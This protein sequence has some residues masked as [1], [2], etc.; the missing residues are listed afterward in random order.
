MNPDSGESGFLLPAFA[1]ALLLSLL[2]CPFVSCV[3]KRPEPEG[4]GMP[5]AGESASSGQ[6]SSTEGGESR[7]A[8]QEPAEQGGVP[9][10]ES[11]PAAD[12]AG[13]VPPGDAPPDESA[14]A[15]DPAGAP[16]P[17]EIADDAVSA[18]PR[19]MHGSLSVRYRGRIDGDDQDHEVGGLLALDLADPGVPWISGH[20][21][22]RV[23]V[24]LEG[25]DDDEV[26]SDLSDTYDS[27]VIPKLYLAYADIA[28]DARPEDSPGT[29]RVGRQSDPRLPEVLRLD[30]LSYLTRPMGEN[31]VEVGAYGGIPVHLYESSAEG[32]LTYGTFVE[33]RPWTDG[34]ARLDWMHLEDELTLGDQRDDLLS[35]GLWQDLARRWRLEAEY[36]HLE[37]DPRDLRLRA[38]FTDPDSETIVRAGY[39]ELLETQRAHATE[40]DPFF[41]QLL[42]HFP[43]RQTTLNVSQAFGVHTV[44]DAGFD[45][46]RVRDSGDVG[47]FN[48]DWERYYATAT[49]H[50]LPAEGVAL[51]VTADR[52]D[53]DDRDTST[54]GADLSYAA[55]ERWEA[56]IGSY[57]SLYKYELLELDERDDVRTYY[58]RA[59][60]ELSA[61]LE[62]EML[63][64]F[65]DD[66]LDTYH[67]LRLGALWRL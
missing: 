66:D 26:F 1:R 50:D 23:D 5:A 64:E 6:S 62:L 37:G 36:S 18:L 46:R 61:R 63:Y 33:G 60:Y 29:L 34:R 40:L 2:S 31:E 11:P 7:A 67:T 39:F 43:F 45:L 9:P 21:Q 38:L 30:G 41:E 8:A 52:W 42:E 59:S 27:N 47:E 17:G 13:A 53:D 55:E 24:D 58:T 49:L 57:Y 54:L 12:P 22:A 20:L 4:A 51:S 35:L 10:D 28:L 32:D 19:W 14:P 65:E 16:P 44:V 48:R 25:S 3:T 15:A 56:A